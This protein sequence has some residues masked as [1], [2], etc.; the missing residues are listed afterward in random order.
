MSYFVNVK[1]LENLKNQFKALAK[2]NHPDAGGDPEVMKAINQEYDKLFQIWKDRYNQTAAQPTHETAASTRSEFYTAYGWKGSKY[3]SGRTTKEVAA[4]VREYV[5][6]NYPGWKFSVRYSHASMCSEV[7]TELKT[8]P[9]PIYKLW[10]ELTQAEA[11]NVWMKAMRNR[12]ISERRVLDAEAE[13][14][15]AAAYERNDWLKIYTESAEKILKDVEREVNSYCFH[16]C[17]G[18]ID[19]FDVNFYYFGCK[20]SHDFKVVPKKERSARAEKKAPAKPVTTDP[21]LQEQEYRV[22]EDVHT[23]T[24]EKIFVVK[25]VRK[26]DRDEYLEVAERMKAIGGYYSRFKHGFIFKEDPTDKLAA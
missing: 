21:D 18:M 4:L 7:H 1:S 14:E 19:Y 22:A 13:Q 8:A 2:K 6:S 17:D 10:Q 26:L 9:E 24:G 5:K 20:P 23:K 16:D 11:I 15:T 3:Q 12:C 25:I